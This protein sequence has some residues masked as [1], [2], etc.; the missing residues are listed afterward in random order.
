MQQKFHKKVFNQREVRMFR[1]QLF[2]NHISFVICLKH[3]LHMLF[4]RF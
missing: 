3:L 1:T 4:D 2:T